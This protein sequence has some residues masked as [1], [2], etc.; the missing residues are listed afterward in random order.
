MPRTTAVAQSC[1]RHH[2]PAPGK[3]AT[4]Q[5]SGG[6]SVIWG[7]VMRN[8][9]SGLYDYT[10]PPRIDRCRDDRWNRRIERPDLYRA[11]D[12]RSTGARRDPSPLPRLSAQRFISA[13][14]RKAR[15]A[16]PSSE[17]E[18]SPTLCARRGRRTP[19]GCAAGSRGRRS[20]GLQPCLLQRQLRLR[21]A[22]TSGDGA[23]GRCAGRQCYDLRNAYTIRENYPFET[24]MLVPVGGVKLSTNTTA[25]RSSRAR[26]AIVDTIQFQ[27]HSWA[28]WPAPSLPVT[29]C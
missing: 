1:P 25:H 12:G 7:P 8:Q 6:W 18:L 28:R 9:Y 2:L 10:F 5:S 4:I 13:S 3:G 24:H 23:C 21:S 19:G 22:A 27:E 16:R 17:S 20:A 11:R 29:I 14:S 15:V 26:S